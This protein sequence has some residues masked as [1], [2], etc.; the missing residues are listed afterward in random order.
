MSANAI[1][2]DGQLVNIDGGGNRISA[3]SFG[4]K[5]VIVLAGLNKVAKTLEDAVERAQ[6]TAAPINAQRFSDSKIPCVETGICTECTEDACIC[7]Y[8]SIVRRCIPPKKIKVLL[9]GE[10]IG[11]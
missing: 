11:Y 8:I 3:I 6:Y 1:S 5:S 9:I 7:N 4:P 10:E 2:E